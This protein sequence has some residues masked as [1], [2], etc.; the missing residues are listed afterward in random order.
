M[1]E[2][3]DEEPAP[4]PG[5]LLAGY[6]SQPYGY[7]VRRSRGTR[8]WLLTFTVGGE[9]H[10]CLDDHTH[11]CLRGDIFM[12]SP[13]TPHDYSTPQDKGSWDFYWAHFTPLTNWIE[14][15]SWSSG[16]LSKLA[17]TDPTEYKR[18]QHAF[19]RMVHDNRDIELFHNELAD[20]A[21]AEILMLLARHH[22]LTTTQQMDP[23]VIQVLHRLTDEFDKNLAMADLAHAV[24]MSPSRLAHLFSAQTGESVM[25]AR[26]RLRMRHATRLLEMTSQSVSNIA[27]AVGFN[28]LFQ[29]S[30]QFSRWHD[31]SPSMYRRRLHDK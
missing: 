21:L 23:R 7:H 4:P 13:G 9:G 10:Y 6:F 14:W 27:H 8:D 25:R 28:S 5:R 11:D 22:M 31:I 1:Q 17:I 16:G 3:L 2:A 20:N 30:R 29:F 26:M 18:L 12:L 24:S 15:L 19:S